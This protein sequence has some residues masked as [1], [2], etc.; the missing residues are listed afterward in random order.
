MNE[1]MTLE[2]LLLETK[3]S[4]TRKTIIIVVLLLI[5]AALITAGVILI[6]RCLETLSNVNAMTVQYGDTMEKANILLE[7]FDKAGLQELVDSL[8]KLS[9]LVQTVSGWFN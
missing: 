9:E 1:N 7:G 5:L 8:S 6:P 3:K 2:A 4:N